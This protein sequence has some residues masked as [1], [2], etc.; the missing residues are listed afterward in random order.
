MRDQWAGDG[1]NVANAEH[2]HSTLAVATAIATTQ[3]EQL[4]GATLLELGPFDQE[5]EAEKDV[6]AGELLA[7]RPTT[8]NDIRVLFAAAS[9]AFARNPEAYRNRSVGS[10][11]LNAARRI[12]EPGVRWR[13]GR[14]P[15]A[16]GAAADPG[17]GSTVRALYELLVREFAAEP[18]GR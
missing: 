7:R 13:G 14:E 9:A 4:G 11:V 12:R 1:L 6:E 5:R 16:A 17:E 10:D 2:A 15:D 8:T 18:Q 3:Y